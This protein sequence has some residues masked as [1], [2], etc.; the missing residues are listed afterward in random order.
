MQSYFII[1]DKWF[2]DRR[3]ITPSFHFNILENFVDVMSEKSQILN[4][5]IKNHILSKPNE[6]LEFFKY[7]NDCT[8]DIIC[9]NLKAIIY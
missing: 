3:L 8:M 1:G 5:R 7:A 6:P 9:G 2:H 4:E